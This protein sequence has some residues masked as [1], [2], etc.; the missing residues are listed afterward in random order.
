MFKQQLFDLI[1][2]YSN[3]KEKR[4]IK[5]GIN[6]SEVYKVI[7]SLPVGKPRVEICQR[8]TVINVKKWM[9]NSHIVDFRHTFRQKNRLLL[10]KIPEFSLHKEVH[11]IGRHLPTK[12]IEGIQCIRKNECNSPWSVNFYI[13]WMFLITTIYQ[14]TREIL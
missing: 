10:E 7:I 12:W 11:R 2:I 3:T 5:N 8:I 4:I 9:D 13:Y 14:E 1:I 6:Q